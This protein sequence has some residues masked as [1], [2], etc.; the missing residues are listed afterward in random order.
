ML[1]N[2]DKYLIM[3]DLDGTLLNSK[4]QLSKE[5][6]EGI[7][8]ITKQGHIFCIATGR[9][10]RASVHIYKEL[11]LDTILVNFNGSYYCNPSN[12]NFSSINLPFSNVV[13][14]RIFSNP[15]VRDTIKNAIIEGESQGSILY[16]LEDDPVTKKEFSEWFHLDKRHNLSVLDGDVSKIKYDLNSI[17]LH[18][19]SAEKFDQMV[20]EVKKAA[21]TLVVRNYSLPVSGEIIEINSIYSNKGNA[22]KYL[23]SY[24]G[25]PLDRCIAFGDGDN[26]VEM[27]SKA[28]YGFAMKNGTKATKLLSRHITKYSNDDNGVV[29][30]LNHFFTSANNGRH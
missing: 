9:P 5:T 14:E 11:N 3:C 2:N 22:L 4:S 12:K 16:S 25:I 21:S 10:R 28:K 6:I 13:A 8:K 23:S 18:V 7:E 27:L 17:L 30:E 19:D 15:V 20:Y 1:T 24:Y 26:D 29:W